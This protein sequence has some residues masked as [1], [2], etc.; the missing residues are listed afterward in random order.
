M[1]LIIFCLFAA[2][3][4]CIAGCSSTITTFDSAGN[5]VKV[6][7]CTDFSRVMDGTNT[8]SQ[9]VLIDGTMLSF[10]A[11]ASAGENCTPGV[12]VRYTNGRTAL[13]NSRDQ[14]SF[15]GTSQVVDKFYSAEVAVT[16]DGITTGR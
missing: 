16:R 15:K 4:V 5:V 10:E 11:S 3:A 7:K 1:K 12:K 14:G 2:S 6:E 9:M 13:I 8:K